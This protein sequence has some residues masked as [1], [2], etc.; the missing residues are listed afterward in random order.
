MD[1]K[2]IPILTLLQQ[3]KSGST[4]PR[5]M[6]KDLRQQV[7]EVLLLEGTSPPQIAQILKVSDKTIRRDIAAIKER[8]ALTPSLELAKKLIGNLIMKAETHRSFLM[9]LARSREGSIGEKAQAEY[10]A[11]KTTD[12]FMKLL[13]T[14][15]YLPLKPKE[16]V[17]DFFH[18]VNDQETEKSFEELKGVLNKVMSVAEEA[19]TVTPEL[20]DSVNT[21]NSRLEKAKIEYEANKLLNNQNSQRKDQNEGN[22]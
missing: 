18:H 14:M 1:N 20:Q 13:Q 12:E 4:D 21:L 11:W 5:G 2:E 16:I 7:E 10:L 3:I 9:R 6:D 19:G 22:I 17:G 15:G 8:N